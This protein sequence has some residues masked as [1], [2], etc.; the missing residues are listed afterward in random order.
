MKQ[1]PTPSDHDPT[2]PTP[3][4][5]VLFARVPT[6][7][8]ARVRVYA[9]RRGISDAAALIVLVESALDQHDQA[10]HWLP[11]DGAR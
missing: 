5:S 7:L 11:A 9:R 1:T 2:P 3:P 4:P 8:K 6:A 10:A